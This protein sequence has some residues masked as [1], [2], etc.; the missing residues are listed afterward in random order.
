MAPV[1]LLNPSCKVR[2][3]SYFCYSVNLKGL[4]FASCYVY[5]YVRHHF[6]LFSVPFYKLWGYLR[7]VF[8][9]RGPA[10]LTVLA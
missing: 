2:L 9:S 5:V 4:E 7:V 1:S 8:E 3:W 6:V 10:E